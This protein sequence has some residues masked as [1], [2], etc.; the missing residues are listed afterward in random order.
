MTRERERQQ[1][2]E[3]A[4]RYHILMQLGSI[5]RVPILHALF[6]LRVRDRFGEVTS[7]RES[8]CHSWV[9]NLYNC[10]IDQ[11]LVAGDAGG[12]FAGI[13]SGYA[14]GSLDKKTITGA[15]WN[16]PYSSL[17]HVETIAGYYCAATVTDGGIIVGTGTG[18]V[19]LDNFEL[20][21]QIAHGSGGGQLEYGEC[22]LDSKGWNASPKYFWSIWTRDFV[23]NSGDAIVV[24]EVGIVNVQ[25]AILLFLRDLVSGGQSVANGAT[26]TVELEFRNSYP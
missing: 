15:S 13:G 3:E 7:E 11:S 18:A 26:L 8:Y 20:D 21:T 10:F 5:M 22:T 17:T 1:F 6:R 19:A 16:L 14:D 23:N 12:P 24:N 9:R 4:A 25:L 2:I